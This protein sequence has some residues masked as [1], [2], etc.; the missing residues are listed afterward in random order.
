MTRILC[1]LVALASVTAIAAEPSATPAALPSPLPAAPESPAPTIAQSVTDLSAQRAA[2]DRSKIYRAGVAYSKWL[3]EI[4]K[5]SGSAF[6]PQPVFER[7][8]WMRLLGSVGALALLSIFAGTFV[9]IMR[10]R[11]G[12]IRSRKHQSALQLAAAALRKPF[13]FFLWM[14]G[15][16]FALMPIATGI[17][18]RP[19]RIFYV[20]LLTAILY[21]GWIVALLWLAFRVILAF[22]KRT[23]EWA[24]R[25]G[26]VVTKVI[27]P[28]AGHTLRLAVPLLG[29]ILLL[30]LL[31][32]P[33]AWTWAIDKGFGILLILAFSF[34]IVR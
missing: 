3:D 8:T 17:I 32:L 13:A 20:G 34:L 29:V 10:R 26:S 28:I 16:A 4:A 22:E 2:A 25:T 27:I 33:E 18:G 19:T 15:G 5:D 9:W 23:N 12:E 7:V 31:R 1:V 30:P 14:C 6:L 11:A 24:Q 21:A